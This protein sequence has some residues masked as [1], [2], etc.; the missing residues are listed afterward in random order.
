MRS[1]NKF[2]LP[3]PDILVVETPEEVQMAKNCHL[4]YIVSNQSDETILLLALY[5]FFSNKFEWVAWEKILN[6]LIGTTNWISKQPIVFVPGTAEDEDS[7]LPSDGEYDENRAADIATDYRYFKG[8][9]DNTLEEVNLFHYIKDAGDYLNVDV[10]MNMKFVPNVLCDLRSMITRDIEGFM[11]SEGYNKKLGM[12]MGNFDSKNEERNLL[13]I[14]VSGSIPQGISNCMLMLIP[15]M[16]ARLGHCDLIVT[17]G[18]SYFYKSGSTLPSPKEMRS[19]IPYSNERDQFANIIESL[20]GK[21]YTNVI[22]FGDNDTPEI[23]GGWREI[24]WEPRPFDNES[25]ISVENVW[26]YHTSYKQ[27]TGYA[28]WVK[29]MNPNVV[30]HIDTSWCRLFNE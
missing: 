28:L 27:P 6:K 9:S 15:T 19:R 18:Q 12:M 20:R 2:G 26:H 29:R 3:L 4:P 21:H 14:D 11:W 16:R 1:L 17:G 5:P 10:L 7:S 13:I 24:M 8:T 22:S 25:I 30:E 23:K